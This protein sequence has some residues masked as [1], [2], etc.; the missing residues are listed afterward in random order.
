MASPITCMET[1]TENVNTINGLE[2]F[3]TITKTCCNCSIGLAKG[4]LELEI[5]KGM[6]FECMKHTHK[7]AKV[8][9]L[10]GKTSWFQP[11]KSHH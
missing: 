6:T 9:S 2:W 5:L 7:T 11:I 1:E 3:N 10:L 8:S 4:Y